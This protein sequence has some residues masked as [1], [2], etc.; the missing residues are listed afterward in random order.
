MHTRHI[1]T[2]LIFFFA[3]LISV[4]WAC[5]EDS[6]EPQSEEFVLPDSNLS[7]VDHI[8]PLFLAKCGSQAGCHSSVNPANGLDL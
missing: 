7:Y 5:S 8:R 6:T 4:Y 1:N 3:V 2:L